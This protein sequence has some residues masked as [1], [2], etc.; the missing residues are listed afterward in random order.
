[1]TFDVNMLIAIAAIV[2]AL[3]VVFLVKRYVG[4]ST[5]KMLTSIISFVR[6][7]LVSA[8]ILSTDTRFMKI[9]DDIV[10]A[11]TLVAAETDD[12][13]PMSEKVNKAYTAFLTYAA[14]AGLTFTDEE[15]ETI[16]TIISA[17]FSFMLTIGMN[18]KQ[19]KRVELKY[20][21][22]SEKLIY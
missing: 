15:K 1:M 11:L 16:K 14:L 10:Q 8:G 2:A 12:T 7:S 5:V 3:V 22:M 4:N 13:V 9:L 19:C 18:Q 20:S 6:N 21:R 17:G